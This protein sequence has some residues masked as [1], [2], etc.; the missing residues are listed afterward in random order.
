MAVTQPHTFSTNVAADIDYVLTQEANR[1]GSDI[2]KAT[3]HQ[4]PWLDLVKQ[5]TFPDGMGYTLN[6]LVY[7]LALPLPTGTDLSTGSDQTPKAS[8]EAIGKTPASSHIGRVDGSYV[9]ENGENISKIDFTR[10]LKSYSLERAVVE[11]PRINVQDLRFAAHRVEQLRAIMDLLKESTR[12]VW[13]S[14]YRDEYGKVCDNIVYAKTASSSTQ[15]GVEGTPLDGIDVDA[16]SGTNDGTIDVTANI[17]NKLLDDIYFKLIRAGAGGNAYGRENGR[18]VFSLV[19]SSEAS[20]QLQ[21]EAGFRDDVRY[22]N[23]QV[24]DLIAPLG[25]EKSFRGFYHLCDDLAPRFTTALKDKADDSPDA[26]ANCLTEVSPYIME[27]SLDKVQVNPAY[28]SADLEA[29]FVLVDNVMESLIPAPLTGGGGGIN[30]DPVNY[31]GDFKWTNIPDVTLNPDG[32]I[33]FFRGILASASKPIKT[34]FGYIILFKRTST[35][36]AA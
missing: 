14:R 32:T 17:S 9:E 6:T 19:L 15:T 25:V 7:D 16:G 29:A 2:H 30:F 31:K 26:G 4:S 20:Y 21:T 12:N 8:W 18:P 35:T 34:N 3:L 36:P 33:G 23:A 10:T 27:E 22:N 11:S 5:T 24:S 13:E 28:D 1:I